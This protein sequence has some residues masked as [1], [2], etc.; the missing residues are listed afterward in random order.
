MKIRFVRKLQVN[1]VVAKDILSGEGKTL[2]KQGI[3]I[4]RQSIK[5]LRENLI[6]YIYIEDEALNDIQTDP[7]LDNLKQKTLAKLPRIFGSI[8][9]GNY[10]DAR[11]DLESVDEL[12]NHIFEKKWVNTNMYEIKTYDNYT[13]IHCLDTSIMVAFIGLEMKYEKSKLRDL[14]I[15]AILHDIGKI[16]IPNNI[17]NKKSK[18]TDE[19]FE[20]IKMHSVYGKE[21]LEK[22]P[23]CTESIIQGVYQ[24]HERIDGKGYPTR[25]YDDEIGEFAKIISI[26]DVFTAV[27]ANRSYRQRFSPNDAYELILAGSG[28]KFDEGMVQKFRNVFFIYPLGACVKLT[29]GVEGYV[30]R[31]N[32]FF[33]DRPVVRIIYDVNTQQ[34]VDIYEINLLEHPNIAVESII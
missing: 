18:L 24:H 23:F 31:Q 6:L 30:V 13:Y 2:I 10:T 3:K 29:N 9:T 33:A 4:T 12:I 1:D 25:T 17:L 14:C 15:A 11:Q 34:K 7:V 26:C 16:K 8:Y 27:S 19:E 20:L 22:V 21:I 28:T 5:F 32:K